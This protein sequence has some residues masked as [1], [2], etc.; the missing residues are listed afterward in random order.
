MAINGVRLHGLIPEIVIADAAF[1]DVPN[2]TAGISRRPARRFLN[3]S[4]FQKSGTAAKFFATALAH[5]KIEFSK[6]TISR[7]RC[8]DSDGIVSVLAPVIR[9]AGQSDGIAVSIIGC[10]IISLRIQERRRS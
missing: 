4:I 5:P 10:V 1:L 8:L 3:K 7:Q 2:A 9:V 6:R